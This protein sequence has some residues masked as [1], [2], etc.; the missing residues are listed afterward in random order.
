MFW[1]P[2]GVYQIAHRALSHRFI[3]VCAWCLARSLSWK[4]SCGFMDLGAGGGHG[5]REDGLG[6]TLTLNKGP[7]AKQRAGKK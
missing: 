1:I 5:G 3:A 4:C 6:R 2:T 7:E